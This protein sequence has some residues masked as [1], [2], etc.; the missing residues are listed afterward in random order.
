VKKLGHDDCYTDLEDTGCMVSYGDLWSPS[1]LTALSGN[2]YGNLCKHKHVI[3][4]IIL[5]GRKSLN[6]FTMETIIIYA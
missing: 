1:P 2:G 3:I 6:S 5:Q 4:N